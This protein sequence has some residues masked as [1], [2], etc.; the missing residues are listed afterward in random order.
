[1]PD[2][3]DILYESTIQTVLENWKFMAWNIAVHAPNDPQ[4]ENKYLPF[5]LAQAAHCM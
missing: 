3:T 2:N 4:M 1:M 5:L